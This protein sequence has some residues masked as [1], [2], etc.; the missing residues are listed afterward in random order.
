MEISCQVYEM[1]D[2]HTFWKSIEDYAK[3]YSQLYSTM[4]L[5]SNKSISHYVGQCAL[6]AILNKTNEKNILTLDRALRRLQ[7]MALSLKVDIILS[8][9]QIVLI[10]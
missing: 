2:Y 1:G 4:P 10:E 8:M 5:C 9:L 7:K 6:D 3:G